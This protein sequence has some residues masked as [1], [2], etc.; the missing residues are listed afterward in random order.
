[1]KLV[2]SP[3]LVAYWGEGRFQVEEFRSRRR[4]SLEPITI[5]L[6]DEFT[7]PRD[8]SRVARSFQPFSPSSVRR[9]IAELL[10]LGFLV[11]LRGDRRRRADATSDLAA[12]WKGCLP[13]AYYHFATRDLQFEMRPRARARL[14]DRLLATPQPPVFKIHRG[15]PKVLLPRHALP[16][17]V[18]L[19][20]SL[21]LRRTVRVFAKRAVSLETFAGTVR[22]TWKQTGWIEG[23]PFG[24]LLTKSSPS[25]GARHPI[26]CYVFALRVESLTPGLYHYS[27]RSDALTRLRRGALAREVVQIASGQSW[28]GDA[29]FVCLMT[30]VVDRTFWKYSPRI[31]YRALYLDAGHL[32]QTFCLVATALGLGPF[33]T[34][35]LQQSKAERLLGVDGVREFP[36]YLC[37]AGIPGRRLTKATAPIF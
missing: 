3:N 30:A 15:K 25:G 31:G 27:V 6:L 21:R 17:S 9:E 35:A 11:S 2:R 24:R 36:I 18:S 37:G 14:F 22:E 34:A 5:L 10:R 32:A 19:G 29:A 20:D 26:E 7:R 1:V 28:I 16:V 33:T 12:S 8:P 4:V 13:A 23:G